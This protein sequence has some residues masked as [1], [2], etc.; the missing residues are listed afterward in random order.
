MAGGLLALARLL[1]FLANS[2]DARH[3]TRGMG[4]QVGAGSRFSLRATDGERPVQRCEEA[5]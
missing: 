4:G 5:D 1:P 2:T 3:V